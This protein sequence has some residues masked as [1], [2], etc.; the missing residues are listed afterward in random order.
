MDLELR[1]KKIFPSDK[2]A[3]YNVAAWEKADSDHIV[4]VGREVYEPG[5]QGKP[6]IGKLVLFEIDRKNTIIH[7]RVI[8]ESIGNSFFLEDPRALT[9]KDGSTTIGL[10][11]VIRTD[12]GF[13]PYPAFVKI[14]SGATWEGV[15][16]PISVIHA[17]GPGKNLTPVKKNKFLF[18][19]EKE[20]YHHKLLFFDINDHNLKSVYDI[21]FPTD[22]PWALWRIGTTMPPIWIDKNQAILIIHGITIQEGKYVYSIGRARFYKKGRKFYVNVYPRPFITPETFSNN[23][24]HTGKELHPEL[25]RVVYACG[26]VV[27]KK[28]PDILNLYVNVGDTTSFEVKIKITDLEKGL[29]ES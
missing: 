26:G 17:F 18:R 16:P 23:K 1:I 21:E 5:T 25:R 8:W 27:R 14:Q 20:G 9:N 4:L 3:R 12:T 11:A 22:L 6:D 7:E 29:F 24:K 15:L 10:T 28:R 13:S 2:P 19:P